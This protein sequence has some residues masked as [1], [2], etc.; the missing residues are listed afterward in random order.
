MSSLY[1]HNNPNV[2]ESLKKNEKCGLTRLEL[3]FNHFE[4]KQ[5]LFYE[6]KIEE[7]G[8]ILRDT[9]ALRYT[10]FALKWQAYCDRIKNC[11]LFVD[12]DASRYIV[13]WSQ[14]R[15]HTFHIQGFEY[16]A[17]DQDPF[18]VCNWLFP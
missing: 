2:Q 10:P 11:V 4:F 18:E 3:R 8:W 6:L 9:N 13:A 5:P 14:T 16:I 7:S 12:K 1:N 15:L 17:K